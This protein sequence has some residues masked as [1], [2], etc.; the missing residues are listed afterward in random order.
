MRGGAARRPFQ[1]RRSRCLLEILRVF[2]SSRFVLPFNHAIRISGK[3]ET[4]TIYEIVNLAI[5]GSF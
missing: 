5:G 4:V 3:W 1:G 2:E